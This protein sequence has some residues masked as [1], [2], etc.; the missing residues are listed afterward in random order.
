LW[1]YDVIFTFARFREAKPTQNAKTETTG[2]KLARKNKHQRALHPSLQI[3]MASESGNASSPW[4]HVQFETSIVSLR[5]G[6]VEEI[7]VFW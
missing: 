1:F 2:H 6:S 5:V 7:S 3:T 4:T